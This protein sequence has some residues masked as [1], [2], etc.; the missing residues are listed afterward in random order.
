MAQDSKSKGIPVILVPGVIMPAMLSYS[1]VLDVLKDEIAAY[2][3]ELEVYKDNTPPLNYN[4]DMEVEGIKRT[5][6]DAGLDTFHLIGYSGGGASSLAF[7]SVYPQR[8]RSLAL[9][10]PAWIG[11]E[12]RT[13]EDIA[14]WNEIEEMLLLPNDERMKAFQRWQ[15]KKGLEPPELPVPK[16]PPPPWL[17]KRPAGIE[18][19]VKAFKVYKLN[20]EKFRN[21]KKPVYYALGSRSRGIYERM[22]NTLKNLFPVMRVEIYE[23]RSHLDP[24]HRAEAER[25]AQALREMWKQ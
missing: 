18:A 12:G 11:N 17:L 25:F 1:Q 14:D 23:G 9:I 22:A 7:T 13:A 6:D 8:L 15:M 5:A 19:L 4:L 21:F 10:E 2:P 16:G 3:K 24:P 20:S